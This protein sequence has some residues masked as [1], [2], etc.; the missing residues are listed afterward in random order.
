MA[1]RFGGVKIGCFGLVL[2]AVGALG[3]QWAFDAFIGAPWAHSVS[4]RPTLT[5]QWTGSIDGSGAPGGSVWLEIIRGSGN[6]RRGVAQR[7]DYMPRGGH[8][9]LHG[10]AVWCRSDGSTTQYKMWGYATHAGD[11]TLVFTLPAGPTATAKELHESHGH[12]DG[13]QLL[14]LGIS[15][16]LYT[17]VPGRN[18]T[19]QPLI[20]DTVRMTLHPA[21]GG[22]GAAS[23]AP[24]RNRS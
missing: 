1:N 13:G 8:P 7:Y 10:T 14:T 6:K 20:G 3:A 2:V 5:G 11:P 17:V 24:A 15:Q 4:G 18:T 16:Q 12:W 21:S 19:T 22:P 23:C 9:T